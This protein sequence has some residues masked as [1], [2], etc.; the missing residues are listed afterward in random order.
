MSF[1]SSTSCFDLTQNIFS[2]KHGISRRFL[3]YFHSLDKTIGERALGQQQT[4]SGKV[5]ATVE[6]ATKQARAVD[7]QRGFTKI[8]NDVRYHV[9]TPLPIH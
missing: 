1:V 8:A 3:D 7:E 5:H 4:V 6:Q 9:V 2:E